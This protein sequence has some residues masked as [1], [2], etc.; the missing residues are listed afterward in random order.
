[1]KDMF[2]VI[3]LNLQLYVVLLLYGL[4]WIILRSHVFGATGSILQ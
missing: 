4:F 2:E 1:M 3:N